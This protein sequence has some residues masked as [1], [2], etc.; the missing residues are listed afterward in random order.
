MK[1]DLNDAYKFMIFCVRALIAQ[2]TGKVVGGVEIDEAIGNAI[3][4]IK[5]VSDVVEDEFFA[6]VAAHGAAGAWKAIHQTAIGN[7]ERAE[8]IAARVHEDNDRDEGEGFYV[9]ED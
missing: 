8:E 2:A 6:N 4:E 7:T 1:D 3:G 9:G 5:P